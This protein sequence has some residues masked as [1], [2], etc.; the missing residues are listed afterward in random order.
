MYHCSPADLRVTRWGH[1]AQT[2][3]RLVAQDNKSAPL[4]TESFQVVKTVKYSL[5][6]QIDKPINN[7]I[8]LTKGV[9]RMII[10]Q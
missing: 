8:A 2:C 6:A 3:I 5:T 7:Q 9:V 10:T 4:V 1:C